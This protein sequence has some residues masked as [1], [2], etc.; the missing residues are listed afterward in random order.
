VLLT[1]E[2]AVG[3]VAITGCFQRAHP[4]SNRPFVA[5][6]KKIIY[7]VKNFTI[8]NI[9]CLNEMMTTQNSR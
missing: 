8:Q 6:L 3:S 7:Y 2:Q 4:G 5:F 1:C 9:E